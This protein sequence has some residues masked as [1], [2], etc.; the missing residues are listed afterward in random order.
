VKR[1]RHSERTKADPSLRFVMTSVGM[2]MSAAI[3]Q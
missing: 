1:N 2:T 3:L